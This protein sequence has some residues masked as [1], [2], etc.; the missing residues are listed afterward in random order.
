MMGKDKKG[1]EDDEDDDRHGGEVGRGA[2]GT[3]QHT[4]HMNFFWAME[5]Q[6]PMGEKMGI[7]AQDPSADV[8]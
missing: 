3:A 6:N 8:T 4:A 2:V 5:I 7:S 1:R